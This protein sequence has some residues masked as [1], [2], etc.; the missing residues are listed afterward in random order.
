MNTTKIGR[1]R[2]ITLSIWIFIL[3]LFLLLLIIMFVSHIEVV[4]GSY[5]FSGWRYQHQTQLKNISYNPCKEMITVFWRFTIFV[6]IQVS[7]NYL[8]NCLNVDQTL[9]ISP[10]ITKKKM[11]CSIASSVRFFFLYRSCFIH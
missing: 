5:V 9:L 6:I 1:E 11:T 8:F 4:E 3:L 2:S 7:S 10:R